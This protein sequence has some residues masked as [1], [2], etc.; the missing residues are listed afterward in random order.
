MRECL[1]VRTVVG[2]DGRS[3]AHRVPEL[4]RVAAPALSGFLGRG[5]CEAVRPDDRRDYDI[6]ILILVK[7]N[8]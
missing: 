8:K 3:A 7:L 1:E 5:D 6:D 2:K 4:L